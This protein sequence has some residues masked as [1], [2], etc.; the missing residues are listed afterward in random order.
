MIGHRLRAECQ[1]RVIDIN[2][3]K[4]IPLSFPLR[5]A[6]PP[7]LAPPA[8]HAVLRASTQLYDPDSEPR[9]EELVDVCIVGGGPAGLSAAIHLKQ[10]EAETGKTYVSSSS[11]RAARWIA[12]T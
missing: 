7:P 9:E 1:R 10:L 6:R 11:R 4:F 2:T 8:Y 5:D 12:C 3:C